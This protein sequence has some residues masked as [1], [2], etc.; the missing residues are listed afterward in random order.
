MVAR[1]VRCA[2]PHLVGAVVLVALFGAV[3]AAHAAPGDLDASWGS[4]GK[5]ILDLGPN[6]S[7]IYA[8]AKQADGKIV[9]AGFADHANSAP[10]DADF[11][12]ARLNA[13]GSLDTTFNPAG[14]PPAVP[15]PPGAGNNDEN[16]APVR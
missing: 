10:F 15:T 1:R 12:V 13:D 7:G 5:V 4:G 8:A 11:M 14:A 3:Q 9:V 2:R 6:P 16:P